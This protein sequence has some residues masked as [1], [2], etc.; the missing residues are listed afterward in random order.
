MVSYGGAAASA[1]GWIPTLSAPWSLASKP[2]DTG[3]RISLPK[4]SVTNELRCHH[5]KGDAI[6]TIT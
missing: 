1:M 5:T 6:P 3:I 4:E 2:E